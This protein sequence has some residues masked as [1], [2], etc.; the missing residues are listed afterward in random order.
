MRLS[1][2]S[3]AIFSSIVALFTWKGT[4]VTMIASRSLRIVSKCTLARMMTEPRPVSKA[5]R[6][7][8]RPRISA[9]VGKSGPGMIAIS[10]AVPMRGSSISA[11]VASITS[12]RLCGGMFVAMPTAMPPAPLTRRFGKR[13]GRTVGSCMES[14]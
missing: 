7:P 2:T 3:S 1:R 6:M 9:P 8:E 5:E 10:S 13:A 14:S 11:M 12:P 4:S